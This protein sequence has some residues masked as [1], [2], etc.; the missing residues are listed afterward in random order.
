MH[1]LDGAADRIAV[2]IWV[3]LCE[4]ASRLHA[5]GRSP[6]DRDHVADDKVGFG[7]GGVDGR[8]VSDLME[9][10]LIP[11]VLVPNRRR[12]RRKS[13]FGTNYHRQRLVLNVDKL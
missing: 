5:I 7:K 10:R 1:R 11:G 6:V 12:T 13:R 3:V 4:A 8:P 9:E 2:L